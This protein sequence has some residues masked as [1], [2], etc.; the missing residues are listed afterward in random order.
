VIFFIC[1]RILLL[2]FFLMDTAI[3]TLPMIPR[4]EIIECTVKAYSVPRLGKHIALTVGDTP[5]MV[6]LKAVADDLRDL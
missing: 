5:V 1:P 4:S 2:F 3:H 6:Y